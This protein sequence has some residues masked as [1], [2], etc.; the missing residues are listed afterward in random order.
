MTASY[1]TPLLVDMK[2]EEL[3]FEEKIKFISFVQCKAKMHHKKIHA[4]VT[5]WRHEQFFNAT[6]ILTHSCILKKKSQRF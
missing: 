6:Q 3:K 5:T 1:D 2:I 4:L